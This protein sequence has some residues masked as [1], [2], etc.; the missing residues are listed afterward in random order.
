[1]APLERDLSICSEFKGRLSKVVPLV[2]LSL[3]GSRAR[4]EAD[5][6]SDFDFLVEVEEADTAVRRAVRRAAWEVAFK[7]NTVFQTTILSREQLSS[8]PERT[9]L[10]VQQAR[11]EGVQI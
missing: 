6:D 8:G 10:M 4:G 9:S 11:R 1:M 7:Y 5:Q 3:F 2:A